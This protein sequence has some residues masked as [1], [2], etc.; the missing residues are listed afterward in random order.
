MRLEVISR[1]PPGRAHPVPL[2]FVHGA[3]H[4]AWCWAEHFLDYFA[5]CGFASHALS[6]RGHGRS[7]G[8]GRLRWTRLAEYVADL[9]LVAAR[10]PSPPVVAG[11][12]LGGAVVQKFLETHEAVAGVLMASVPPA[13][14]LAATWR[15]ARRHPLLLAKVNLTAT[16]F[17][18][19]ASPS[20]ARE[21]FF[22]RGLPDERVSVY[23]G[24]LQDESYLAFL[25]VLGLDL[26]RPEA[27]V[28]VP[29]LVLGAAEDTFFTPREVEATARAYGT[30]AEI[31][32][33][34][35]HDM[36]LEPGWQ[37]VAERI[38]RWLEDTCPE[39]GLFD[40]LRRRGTRSVAPFDG[41]QSTPRMKE[42]IT[43]WPLSSTL[44]VWT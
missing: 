9:A 36:M 21:A 6:L 42:Q 37:G 5:S 30:R 15:L 26:P 40:R 13:G 39:G 11:H 38:V 23:A 43:C 14:A 28:D 24:R 17:P 33:E 3:W 29:I 35:A 16:L 7:E 27:V 25:D 34:M 44:N 32:T 41:G 1:H 22:S 8:R 20:L 4:G 12:S 19:V 2:L 31:F 18:L 10:L